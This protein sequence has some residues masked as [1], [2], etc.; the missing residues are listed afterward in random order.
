MVVNL[1]AGGSPQRLVGVDRRSAEVLRHT[2]LRRGRRLLASG[3]RGGDGV[4]LQLVRGVGQR[5][6]VLVHGIRSGLLREE[7]ERQQHQ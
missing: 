3:R 5:V 7:T 4:F 6:P 2:H 1:E